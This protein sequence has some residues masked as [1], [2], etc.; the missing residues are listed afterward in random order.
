MVADAQAD[1]DD[2]DNDNES[3]PFLS[4]AA[5]DEPALVQD[6]LLHQQIS[7][8]DDE[9]SIPRPHKQA[10]WS[11]TVIAGLL[12][13][14]ILLVGCSDQIES[15]SSTRIYEAIYCRQYYETRDPGLIGGDGWV[16]EGRCKI[17][18]VQ[19]S[20][21]MLKAWSGVFDIAGSL[22]FAIPWGYFADTHGRKPLILLIGVSMIARSVWINVVCNFWRTFPIKL[23]WLGGLSSITGGTPVLAAVAYTVIADIYPSEKRTTMFF[24]ITATE[25]FTKFF[26]PPVATALMRLSPF[27]A[28]MVSTGFL[29]IC[30]PILLLIPETLNYRTKTT[31]TP[32]PPHPKPNWTRH[33]FTHTLRTLPSRI[34]TSTSFLTR[35]RSLL[36]LLPAYTPHLLIPSTVALIPQ[37]ASARFTVPLSTAALLTSIQGLLVVLNLVLVLP[38]ATR[39][40][41]HKYHHPPPSA[42]LLLARLSAVALTTGFLL[43]GL[44]PSL[45][46]LIAV[47][48]VE[49]AGYGVMILVRSVA[50]SLVE[51]HHIARLYT[52]LSVCE[53]AGMM[54]WSPLIAK[55]LETG[56][57]VGG[58]AMGLPFFVTGGLM[59][60]LVGVLAGPCEKKFRVCSTERDRQLARTKMNATIERC[61]ISASPEN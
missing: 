44:A 42:D 49:V 17:P 34:A 23:V 26:S 14:L 6:L 56:L 32:L 24:R 47:L 4:I 53:V 16:E 11:P 38:L 43:I 27:L 3:T 25:L 31:K 60:A 8:Q 9:E 2:D 36:I 7:D 45:P 50:T 5:A 51:R 41:V 20:V 55:L 33:T 46:L 57:R 35:S 37:Y 58:V 28:M 10:K 30:L 54:A 48:P 59:A 21:A 61:S 18:G 29:I 52:V 22:P 19:G 40:L 39:H 13:V 15:P 12:F 1:W